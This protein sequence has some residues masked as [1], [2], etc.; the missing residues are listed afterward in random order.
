MDYGTVYAFKDGL[1]SLTCSNRLVLI[2]PHNLQDYRN[3]GLAVTRW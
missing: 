1:K 2:S 3:L